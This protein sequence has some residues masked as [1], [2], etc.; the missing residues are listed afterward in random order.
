MLTDI[1]VYN[2]KNERSLTNTAIYA[3]DM[4]KRTE[5]SQSSQF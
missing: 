4:T 1:E 2:E 3:L 5:M